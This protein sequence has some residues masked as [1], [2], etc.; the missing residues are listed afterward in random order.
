MSPRPSEAARLTQQLLDAGLNRS[1]VADLLDRDASLVTQFFTRGKGASFVPA[2]QHVLQAVREG[3]RDR[4]TLRGI[5]QQH[6]SRRLAASGQQAR[7]R[8]KDVVG[9][10]G[11]SA[12]GRAGQQAI[13]HGAA[14]LAK[15]VHAAGQAR[16]RL[17]FTVRMAASQYVY[18]PGSEDDSPGL[19]RGVLPRTDGTE[20]RSY[21]SMRTGGFDAAEWSRRVADHH[22]DVTA[23]VQAWM[24]ETGRAVPDARIDFLEVRTWIPR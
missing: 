7:V 13:A 17:A 14:H 3:E 11:R 4:D 9:T 22:G 23:A 16:G 5:A 12:A 10:L 18:H 2:L 8:G 24:T 6:V 20:E 1:Q 19:K 21:G 15:V